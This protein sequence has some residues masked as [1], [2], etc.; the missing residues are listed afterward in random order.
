MFAVFW[1][2]ARLKLSTGS[3][4]LQLVSFAHGWSDESTDWKVMIIK[5][6]LKSY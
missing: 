4:E 1:N 5:Q 2:V 6:L 3:T